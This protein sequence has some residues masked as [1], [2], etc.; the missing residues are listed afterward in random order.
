MAN[1]TH[2]TAPTKFVEADG[3][4]FGLSPF[5]KAK[6]NPFVFLQY[7][8]ADLAVV[9]GFAAAFAE[10]AANRLSRFEPRRL[11]STR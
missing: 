3:I 2:E 6:G 5:R 8:N 10:R 9:N 1:Q 7:F 11:L 4:R